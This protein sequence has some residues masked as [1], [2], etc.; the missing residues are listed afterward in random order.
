MLGDF[1]EALAVCFG[2]KWEWVLGL[3]LLLHL[4]GG[5]RSP[6]HPGFKKATRGELKRAA[7]LE[8]PR[9]W[10]GARSIFC[11]L[12]GT[13]IHPAPGNGATPHS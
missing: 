13:P 4:T 11:S 5:K 10:C 1:E 6:L 7:G 12:Y 3:S 8:V 2:L 9:G